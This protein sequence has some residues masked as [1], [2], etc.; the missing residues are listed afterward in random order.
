MSEQDADKGYDSDALVA[1]LEARD[2]RD[3]PLKK[4]RAQL[5]R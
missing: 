3:S 5:K 4:R 1:R 2:L